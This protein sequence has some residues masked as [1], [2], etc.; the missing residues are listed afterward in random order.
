MKQVTFVD[1]EYASKCKQTRKELFLIEMDQEGFDW[2]D[3]AALLEGRRWSPDLSVD[4]WFGYSDL[5]G[6]LRRALS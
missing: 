5:A 2:L 4:G 1:T 3:R 6:R